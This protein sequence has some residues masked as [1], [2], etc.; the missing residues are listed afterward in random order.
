MKTQSIA[1]QTFP[2]RLLL[3]EHSARVRALMHTS[4]VFL[5]HSSFVVLKR[6]LCHRHINYCIHMHFHDNPTN[7]QH[8]SAHT[9]EVPKSRL[10]YTTEDPPSD[11]ARNTLVRP[12]RFPPQ[13]LSQT[14]ATRTS[15][16]TSTCPSPATRCKVQP[17]V[18]TT[19]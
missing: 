4:Q 8:Q 19:V 18:R 13:V 12:N 15:L 11:T 6:K 10:Y 1:R 9:H 14:C 16:R 3:R 7:T 2:A 17:N 5:S